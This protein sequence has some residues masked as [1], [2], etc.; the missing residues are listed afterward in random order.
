[1]HAIQEHTICMI[2][3]DMLI[4]VSVSCSASIG[5]PTAVGITFAVTFLIS[6]S[7]GALVATIIICVCYI[8]RVS[9][10][11]TEAPPSIPTA[12]TCEVVGINQKSTNTIELES[13]AA[14][15]T[16]K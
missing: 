4:S 12:T 15:G 7:L 3:A 9:S 1:M 6:S 2:Y 10:M 5:T 13:N 14:Y 11:T 16:A 8:P